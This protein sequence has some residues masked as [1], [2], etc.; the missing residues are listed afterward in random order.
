MSLVNFGVEPTVGTIRSAFALLGSAF[1]P[2]V[3]LFKLIFKPL[4]TA[5][6]YSFVSETERM[7]KIQRVL[8]TQL[9]VVFEAIPNLLRRFVELLARKQVE[10][11]GDLTNIDPLVK[12]IIAPLAPELPDDEQV[13]DSQSAVITDSLLAGQ[14]S[15]RRRESLRL[16]TPASPHHAK[17]MSNIINQSNLRS[18]CA[19]QSSIRARIGSQT[20]IYADDENRPNNHDAS[21]TKPGPA[22]CIKVD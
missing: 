1:T 10:E 22:Q 20:Q 5:A 9:R 7:R 18:A 8:T 21:A 15:S 16:R 12:K 17:I 13:T 3:N 14:T 2:L 19:D 11:G 4:N 6:S